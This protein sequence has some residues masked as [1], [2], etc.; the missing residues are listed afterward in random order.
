MSSS[1]GNRVK[2]S[3]FGE[4]HGEAIGCVLDGLPAGEAID[5]EEILVQM[6]RRAPGRDKSATPRRETDT[7]HILS[8]VFE[9][10]TTGAPLAMT[11]TNENT[12]S[13]DY[14]ELARKPRPGHS[15][16]AAH[17][18]YDGFND[19]RGGGHFS[20][21]LTATL[22]FAGA[23][24][25]QILR[26]RGV[27]IGGHVLEI[28]GVRDRNF[29][30]VEIDAPMLERL[31]ST[32][33]SVLNPTVEEAMRGE[34]EAA[35]MEQDSVGGIVE[36][37]AVGLPAGLGS[38]MFEGVENRLAAMLF[39]IPAVKGL[40]FGAGFGF[41]SMRGSQAN[42]PYQYN[43]DGCVVT[44]SNNNGG[45]LGGITNGMPLIVRACVKPTPS[46]SLPQKTIDLVEGRNTELSVHGRHDP[47]IVPRALPVVES[48][49][50]LCLLDLMETEQ[51][52]K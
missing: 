27:T 25:R 41:A 13:G 2:I 38:P 22:V 11:I 51:Y 12:R 20:G 36:A 48:V 29:D 47:C 15:D 26:R 44:A 17:V 39:G 45:L 40:E 42:D 8:G 14:S 19:I 6:A 1:I 5:M 4:S 24:C 52:E 50:A 46:I 31:A 32:P 3:V 10:H 37:A 16:Y 23:V 30:P 43:A 49:M 9:G 21:R 7:P 35:R 18:R 33:F 34:I 28:H